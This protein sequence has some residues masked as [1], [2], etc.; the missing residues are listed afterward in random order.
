[1]IDLMLNADNV[2]VTLMYKN[3]TQIVKEPVLVSAQGRGGGGQTT[4]WEGWLWIYILDLMRV[5]EELRY[6][7][8]IEKCKRRPDKAVEC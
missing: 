8:D 2:L 6:G 1:M 4:T 7:G 3:C 5:S